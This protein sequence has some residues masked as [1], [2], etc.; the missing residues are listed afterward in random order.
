MRRK[1]A[2]V[3]QETL[4]KIQPLFAPQPD[5]DEILHAGQ[6]GAE[7]QQENLRQRIRHAPLT[8]AHPVL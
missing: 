3:R 8:A 6:G 4:R 1:A 7:R 5:L 2:L